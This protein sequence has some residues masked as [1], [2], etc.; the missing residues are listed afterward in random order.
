MLTIFDDIWSKL[1]LL[2]KQLRDT[3]QF[4]NQTKQELAWN[5]EVNTLHTRMQA[6]DKSYVASELGAIGSIIGGGATL[7][8]GLQGGESGLLLGQSVGQTS[9]GIFNWSASSE[10]RQSEQE[11]SVADL[12]DKGAQAY[13]KTLNDTLEKAHEVMQQMM[14]L[15]RNLVEVLSMM[16][17]AVAR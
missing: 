14:S 7:G 1:L 8:F 12:Q 6:I 13:V 17:R 4:Y 10:T 16:L 11:R 15:G 9:S 3:M 5:L 2:A